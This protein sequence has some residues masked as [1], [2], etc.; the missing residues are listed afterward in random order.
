MELSDLIDLQ[1]KIAQLQS[2]MGTQL[3][4][5]NIR[6]TE[7]VNKMLGLLPKRGFNI[8]GSFVSISYGLHGRWNLQG[9]IVVTFNPDHTRGTAFLINMSLDENMSLMRIVDSVESDLLSWIEEE[10]ARMQLSKKGTH[11]Y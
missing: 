10:K 4:K 9:H 8:T 7:E 1:E 6:L 5:L 2:Q 3:K 11:A